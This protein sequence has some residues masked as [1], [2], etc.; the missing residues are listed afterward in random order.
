MKFLA[1]LLGKLSMFAAK[2]IGKG[3][4]FP[5][6]LAR[7]IDK[8]ILYK[9]KYPDIRVFVSGSS[10]KGSSTK[11]IT[12]VLRANGYKVTCNDNGANM[13]GGILST[14][15]GEMTLGG[16]L[17]S[18]VIVFEMDERC[19]KFVYDA[20]RPTHLLLTN[21]T[22]DQPPRQHDPDFILSEVL[23]NIPDSTVIITNGDDPFMRNVETAVSNSVVYYS[24]GEN[25]YSYKE[26]IFENLI[27]NHCPVCGAPLK[28]DYFNFETLGRYHCTACDWG[29][30]E[31]EYT[32]TELDLDKGVL[33]TDGREMS[34]GGD[35]LFNAYNVIGAYSLLKKLGLDFDLI[36]AINA[37]NT[38][39]PSYF[40]AHGKV[41]YALN[42]KAENAST[43]NQVT[44]KSYL[45]PGKKDYVIGWKEISRRY[46]HF[47]LSWLYDIAFELL[48]NENLNKVYCAGIDAENIKQM[49]IIA[50]IE[51]ERI[52]TAVDIPAI[53]E[54]VLA[55]DV[56]AVCGI[57]NFDYISPFKETFMEA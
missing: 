36:D 44:Y 54:M 27:I 42:C 38:F 37:F 3:S 24:L 13:V 43:Y 21:L 32:G 35:V 9:I 49:L 23:R 10:G 19:T 33:K 56:D 53:R 1:I 15:L 8:N 30:R 2:L 51:E 5:G 16:K 39:K 47:D 34:I 46:V 6:D 40:K 57:L 25:R 14:M 7:K 26:Q 4:S 20:I 17:K 11:I 18:D 52:V 45:V 31:T 12:G 41:F 28:Y 55:D 29:Y 48:N 22:K 50:G